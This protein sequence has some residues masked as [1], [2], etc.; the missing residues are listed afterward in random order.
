MKLSEN[1][2]ILMSD[3]ELQKLTVGEL[4]LHNIEFDPTFPRLFERETKQIFLVLGSK[5]LQVE[6]VGSTSNF[7]IVI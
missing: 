4:K 2:S 3:E 1:S 6:H 7:I 5:A